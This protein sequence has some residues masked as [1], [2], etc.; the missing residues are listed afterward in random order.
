MNKS[1]QLVFSWFHEEVR[2]SRRRRK[3]SLF[4]KLR[5]PPQIGQKI[6]FRT[7]CGIE[8]GVL[9][10]VRQGLVWKEYAMKNGKIAA[11]S[12]MVMHPGN[13]EWRHPSLVVE[14]EVALTVQRIKAAHDADPNLDVTQIAPICSDFCQLQTYLFL[15][16]RLEQERKDAAFFRIKPRI[17][18]A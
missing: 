11:E 17:Q 18:P 15:R 2:D 13:A 10:A 3:N 6:A 9:Q 1:S 14:S 5:W 12:E 8:M 16:K 7:D 4:P